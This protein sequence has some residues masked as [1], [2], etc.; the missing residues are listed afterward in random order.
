MEPKTIII[1]DEHGQEHTFNVLFTHTT[2]EKVSFV[3]YVDPKDENQVF[4]ARYDDQGKLYDLNDKERTF[5]SALLKRYDDAEAD[6][7]DED[8]SDLKEEKS[9]I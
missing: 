1:T 5:A 6:E 3:F 7:D 8:D 2:K 4:C 9:G